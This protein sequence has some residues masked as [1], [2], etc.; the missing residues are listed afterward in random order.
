[1]SEGA[2]G[3]D[4]A[5]IAGPALQCRIGDDA[6]ASL[7]PGVSPAVM[8]GKA[9]GATR[10]TVT[11]APRQQSVDLVVLASPTDLRGVLDLL[12]NGRD[13]PGASQVRSDG[14]PGAHSAA[15]RETDLARRYLT[16]LLGV[17]A[18]R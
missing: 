18:P 5:I 2:D 15:Q 17:E 9:A 16:G 13:L 12:P 3:A 7:V 10:I 14:Q 1:M 4:G 8:T 11:A 6:V